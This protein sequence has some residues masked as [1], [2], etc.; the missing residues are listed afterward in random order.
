MVVNIIIAA[1]A[2]LVVIC[3]IF[4]AVTYTPQQMKNHFIDGQCIVGKV[5]ANA[6]YGL[7]WALKGLKFILTSAVA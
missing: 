1:V 2:A 6:F 5:C 3:N 7:A 4:V